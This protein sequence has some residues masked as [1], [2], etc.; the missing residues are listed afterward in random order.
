MLQLPCWAYWMNELLG[1][2]V[3][4]LYIF[5][6]DGGLAGLSGLSADCKYYT[7]ETNLKIILLSIPE[8]I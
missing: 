5:K 1:K 6:E 8:V 2:F 7:P 4:T 3:C